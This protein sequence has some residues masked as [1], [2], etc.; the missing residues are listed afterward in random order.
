MHFVHIKC[1]TFRR[2]PCSERELHLLGVFSL[3]ALLLLV[4]NPTR[5]LTC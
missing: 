5:L 1:V 2:F 4:K 3:N